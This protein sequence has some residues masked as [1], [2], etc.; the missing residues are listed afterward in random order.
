MYGNLELTG[1]HVAH[2]MATE[3]EF[4]LRP[5]RVIVHSINEDGAAS[6]GRLLEKHRFD[7]CLTPFSESELSPEGV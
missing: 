2:F 1:Y 7:F 6:I 5:D 4:K 3:L